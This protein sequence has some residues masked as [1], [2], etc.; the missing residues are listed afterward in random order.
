M[1]G[2]KGN[3]FEL[4]LSFIG[5]ALLG[6]IVA[7]ILLAILSSFLPTILVYVVSYLVLA[8]LEVYIY[9]TQANFYN[10]VVRKSMYN[11]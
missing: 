5:W 3:L 9:V 6:G 8:P 1:K 7:P 11:M 4:Q 2:H 10:E